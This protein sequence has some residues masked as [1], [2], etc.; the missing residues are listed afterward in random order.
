MK[1]RPGGGLKRLALLALLGVAGPMEARADIRWNW[2]YLN[3]DA[4]I[5]ASGTLTTKDLSTGSYVITAV[6]GLWNG[7]AIAGLEPDHSCCSP[8]GWNDNLLVEGSPKLDKGGFAFR[9]S[10]NLKINLFFKNGGY[11]YEIQNG[12]EVFGGV[13]NAT[14]SAAE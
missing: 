1:T 10:G 8:P 3:T 14:P 7:A 5:T 12:P 9:A 4:K 2:S 13:F 11:A 6:T